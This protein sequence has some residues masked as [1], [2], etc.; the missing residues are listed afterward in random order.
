MVDFQADVYLLRIARAVIRG[1]HDILYI[2]GAIIGLTVA[3]IIAVIV[4]IFDWWF[5]D[6]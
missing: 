6:H 1:F 5:G 4:A 2:V 3:G